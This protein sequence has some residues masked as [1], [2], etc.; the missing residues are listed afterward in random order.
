MELRQYLNIIRRRWW[1][2]LFCPM[3]AAATAFGVSRRLTPIYSA[4]ATLLLNLAAQQTAPSF[5]DITASQALTKT[6]AQL[7]TARPTLDEAARRLGN[8]ASYGTIKGV[9]GS[10]VPQTELLRVSF[11]SKNPAFAANVVNIVSQVF[12]ERVKQAQL[13]DIGGQ[14]ATATSNGLNT[15]FIADPAVPPTLP[16]SPRVGLNTGLAAI[17]GLLFALGIAAMMEYLDDTVKGPEDLE[18]LGL[19]LMGIVQRQ[20]A[21]AGE[22]LSVLS[23]QNVS[24]PAAEGYRQLRTNIEFASLDGDIRSLVITSAQ[25]GEGKTTTAGNL[26]I[27][28]AK[29]G[30]SVILVDTDLRRPAIHT[31]FGLTNQAGLT[32]ALLAH[33]P[34]YEE[35]V[36]QSAPIANLRILTTGPLPPNPAE[37]LAS[38]KMLG[39]MHNLLGKADII[40]YDSPPTVAVADA[41]IVA[42]HVDGVLLVIDAGNT[43]LNAVRTALDNLNR[44]KTRIVGTVLNKVS[45]RGSGDKYY[46][47]SQQYGQ[48]TSAPTTKE[49]TVEQ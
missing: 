22:S 15:V 39:I 35:S 18:A 1:L 41:A 49:V 23:P 32:T 29:A 25:P 47:Y 34:D 20:R 37:M 10:D 19:P 28:L 6:Y 9:S 40:V 26:A 13:G 8:G 4:Q 38:P 48:Y 2:L 3:I 31:F 42:A 46:Y 24:G 30:K 16:I 5:G 33:L 14:A 44:S 21:V 43:R 45:A 12:A 11:S 27:M 7:I 17:V 36:L